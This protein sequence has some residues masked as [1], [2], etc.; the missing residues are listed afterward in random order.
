MESVESIE[1]LKKLVLPK[2]LLEPMTTQA[3]ESVHK[4][5][6]PKNM[7]GIWDFPFKLGRE[8]RISF[9]D[10]EQVVME[11]K[12]A[13]RHKP[14]NNIYLVDAGERLQISRE[15]ISIEF[16][17]NKYRL[18]DRGSACGTRVNTQATGGRDH[19]GELSLKD[20]DLIKLGTEESHYIFKFIVLS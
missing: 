11:R 12:R 1:S 9:V 8:S 3:K 7:I 6:L 18:I 10:G 15:H 20:G 16:S 13:D 17:D 5:C 4:G 14:N 2:V 19:S